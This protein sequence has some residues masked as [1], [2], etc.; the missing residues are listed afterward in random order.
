MLRL[1][2]ERARIQIFFGDINPNTYICHVSDR[3]LTL[4]KVQDATADRAATT[5][6][7]WKRK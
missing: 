1:E 5:S 6:G 7:V 4:K 3:Q 2:P